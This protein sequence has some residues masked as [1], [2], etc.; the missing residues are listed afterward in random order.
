[1]LH[2]RFPPEYAAT[3]ARHAVNLKAV[4]NS[5]DDL[6]SFVMLP[7]GLL[8]SGLFPPFLSSFARCRRDPDVSSFPAEGGRER[9]AVRPAHAP[10]PSARTVQRREQ[11]RAARKKERGIR[12]REQ[13]DEEFRLREQPGLSPPTTSEDSLSGDEEEEESDGGQAPTERWEPAPPHRE[14]RRRQRSTH[15]GRARKRPP[16]GGLRKRKRAPRRCRCASRRCRRAPR[17]RLEARRWRRRPWPQRPPSP[18]GRGSGFLHPEVVHRSSRRSIWRVVS[19]IFLISR[20]QG[21]ADR[22]PLRPQRRLGQTRPSP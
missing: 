5:N 1:L 17:R 10:G 7:D 8:V 20:S 15:L 12:R 19:L 18:R 2:D 6:W 21:G 14:P 9:S 22:P 3:R 4:M 13:R 16:P 11:E